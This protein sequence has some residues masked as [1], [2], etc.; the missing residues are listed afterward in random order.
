MLLEVKAMLIS[1]VINLGKPRARE[2]GGGGAKE[3]SIIR[4]FLE[5][6]FGHAEALWG[7]DTCEDIWGVGGG[8]D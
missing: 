4:V 5:P 6:L 3:A 8:H 7:G 2:G 1:K